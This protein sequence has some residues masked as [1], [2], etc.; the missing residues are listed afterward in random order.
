MTEMIMELLSRLESVAPHIWAWAM[1]QV[2]VSAMLNTMIGIAC[3][4]FVIW[5]YLKV[6]A[7]PG[8]KYDDKAIA[9]GGWLFLTA[10]AG[11]TGIA[12]LNSAVQ[13]FLNPQWQ[14][15]RLVVRLFAIQ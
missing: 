6:R 1:Q 15:V 14:A 12:R 3:L 5:T 10:I 2:W 7:L 11:I 9:W 13:C 8:A 4:S